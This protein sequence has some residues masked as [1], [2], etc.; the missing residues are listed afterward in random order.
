MTLELCVKILFLVVIKKGQLSSL[1]QF[2]WKK[3][4]VGVK[5]AKI[6]NESHLKF[7]SKH[8]DE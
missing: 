2:H 6:V 4:W 1:L 5:F 8:Q 7:N 3:P